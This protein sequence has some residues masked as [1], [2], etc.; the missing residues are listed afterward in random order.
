MTLG[1]LIKYP[2]FSFTF[3]TIQD[4]PQFVN[5]LLQSHL[6]LQGFL[7]HSTGCAG[8]QQG[9]EWQH[10]I[11]NFSTLRV[12]SF[13]H[14]LLRRGT[15]LLTHPMTSRFQFPKALQPLIIAWGRFKALLFLVPR[16]TMMLS[17]KLRSMCANTATSISFPVSVSILS[18]GR[19]FVQ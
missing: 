9:A 5:L 3:K 7:Q 19:S 11:R 6:Y 2:V 4:Y 16:N 10:L 14:R 15:A 17:M 18:S 12:F 13:P 8:V 1:D